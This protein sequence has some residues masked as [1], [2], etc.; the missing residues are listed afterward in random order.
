MCCN[1]FD[2]Y[3]ALCFVSTIKIHTELW[4][5]FHN[6]LCISV[7]E[8]K[9]LLL[10]IVSIYICIWILLGLHEYEIGIFMFEKIYEYKSK[11]HF[12]HNQQS[13]ILLPKNSNLKLNNLPQAN[14]QLFTR[15]YCFPVV[16]FSFLD[17]TTNERQNLTKLIF[18]QSVICSKLFVITLQV[19]H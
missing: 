10:C 9:S 1:N 16:G 5:S 4:P 17:I 7:L 15:R 8:N 3:Y 13:I 14:S 6:E 19:F 2:I 12:A 18:V 11:S